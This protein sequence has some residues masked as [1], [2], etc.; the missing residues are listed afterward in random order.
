MLKNILNLG[1]TLNKQEQK[2]VNGGYDPAI[3]CPN[4]DFTCKTGR[5]NILGNCY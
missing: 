3:I 4:D 5:C 2:K 1:T